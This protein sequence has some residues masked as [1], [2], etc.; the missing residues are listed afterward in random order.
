M[1]VKTGRGDHCGG[2]LLGNDLGS[3]LGGELVEALAVVHLRK[4][5]GVR[6]LLGGDHALRVVL[7]VVGR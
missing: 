2:H 3:R 1:I 7:A 5:F 4:D 6:K